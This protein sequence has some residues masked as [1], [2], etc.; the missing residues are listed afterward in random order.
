MVHAL[1]FPSSDLLKNAPPLGIIFQMR[2]KEMFFHHFF[3]ILGGVGICFLVAFQWCWVLNFFD[4]TYSIYKS[5]CLGKK[6][7]L[8]IYSSSWSLV[9]EKVRFCWGKNEKF[10]LIFIFFF[11]FYWISSKLAVGTAQ[12]I[13]D[14]VDFMHLDWW[15]SVGLCARA[16]M[17]RC[18]WVHV[19][20]FLATFD[21]TSAQF[22]Y[23]SHPSTYYCA[24][25]INKRNLVRQCNT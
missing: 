18:C 23:P 25:R 1:V 24:I 2:R 14:W 3:L 21:Y 15:T 16:A 7:L 4:T 10:E 5:I 19:K 6:A 9:L 20:V 11:L 22:A 8:S 12:P 13:T 17:A